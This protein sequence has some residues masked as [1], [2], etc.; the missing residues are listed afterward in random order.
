MK[1]TCMFV[2]MF[3][4]CCTLGL[5]VS[6]S[7]SQKEDIK[8]WAYK[9]NVS[10]SEPGEGNR[11]DYPLELSIPFTEGKMKDNLQD[12]RII[13]KE[14]NSLPFNFYQ[15]EDKLYLFF[16]VDDIARSAKKEYTIYYGNPKS[17]SPPILSWQEFV[18]NPNNL[19]SAPAFED[20]TKMERWKKVW[21][22][23]KDP[24]AYYLGEVPGDGL[25]PDY[26]HSGVHSMRIVGVSAGNPGRKRER[27]SISQVDICFDPRLKKGR[28]V[29][30]CGWTKTI[31][32]NP[33]GGGLGYSAQYEYIKKPYE[34]Q[35]LE[36]PKT[37]HDWEYAS[38]T[39]S[40]KKNCKR[41][42]RISLM[43]YNQ[44]G[45]VYFDDIMVIR[46]PLKIA[47]ETETLNK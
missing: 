10:V 41:I 35:N 18:C 44:T 12:I 45:N 32:I 28:E 3:V 24:L 36:C 22:Y 43:Y 11:K 9:I 38:N 20:L 27:K 16:I 19:I 39:F 26:F 42:I 17:E 5:P 8:P 31:D 25:T 2:I 13:D 23:S 37:A 15:K 30:I 6:G 29:K 33:S 46:A 7:P 4:V 1:K 34:Y 47:I 40:V 21:A 14:G